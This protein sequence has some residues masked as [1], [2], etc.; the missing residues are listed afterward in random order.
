MT[1]LKKGACQ[2]F[3]SYIKLVIRHKCINKIRDT[4]RYE[5]HFD[6]SYMGGD[7]I[8]HITDKGVC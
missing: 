7:K 5:S 3:D 6:R 4:Y 2:R 8:V 1:A